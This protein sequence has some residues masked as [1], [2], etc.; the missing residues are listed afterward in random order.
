MCPRMVSQMINSGMDDLPPD[1]EEQI[2]E[3][4]GLDQPVYVQYT[5]WIRNIVMKGDFGYSFVYRKDAKEIIFERLPASFAISGFSL[6]FIWIVALPIG[7]Y[8][9]VKQ[10][11]LTDYMVTFIGF[12]GLAVP[13]FLF[14]LVL[15][16]ISYKYMDQ[17]MIGLFSREYEDAPWS[18]GKFCGLG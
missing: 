17:A 4:Y 5:K 15:M 8:S 11:S 6:L 9:A 12:V 2:R 16:F 3:Q 18:L 13:S 14:A 7:I 10:Y 1:F